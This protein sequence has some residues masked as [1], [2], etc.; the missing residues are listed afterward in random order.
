MAGYQIEITEDA[1]EDLRY[2]TAFERKIIVSEIRT[3]L[4][5]QPSVETKNR[6]QLRDNPIATWELRSGKYRVFYEVDED[7]RIVSVVSAGH[8]EHNIPFIRG[9]EVQI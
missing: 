2:Y 9:K 1:N 3:Q 6:K 5:Y 4:A 7:A 8:K